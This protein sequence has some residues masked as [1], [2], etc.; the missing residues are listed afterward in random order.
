[1]FEDSFGPVSFAPTDFLSALFT[2]LVFGFACF[3]LLTIIGLIG[4]SWDK[5]STDRRQHRLFAK[6]ILV[7]RRAA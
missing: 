7:L 1:M 4:L 5:F 3:I 2:D 6:R